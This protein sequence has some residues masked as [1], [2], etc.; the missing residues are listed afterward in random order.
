M[1]LLWRLTKQF[2]GKLLIGAVLSLSLIMGG[3]ALADDKNGE[4]APDSTHTG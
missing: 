4:G 3:V 2:N 1:Q